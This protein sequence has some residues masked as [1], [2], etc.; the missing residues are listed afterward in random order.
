MC[1][2]IL[3]LFFSDLGIFHHWVSSCHWTRRL[4]LWWF[5]HVFRNLSSLHRYGCWLWRCNLRYPQ[6]KV[7]FLGCPRW[8]LLA[9]EC[10]YFGRRSLVCQSW[11]PRLWQSRGEG[12]R[13][14]GGWSWIWLLYRVFS[15]WG[16]GLWVSRT[17][18]TG[19]FSRRRWY[20]FSWIGLGWMNKWGKM[21]IVRR[22]G[23]WRFERRGNFWH[24]IFW[25]YLRY[26]MS[27]F[28][29]CLA[30]IS[31]LPR[32]DCDLSVRKF[33]PWRRYSR[34]KPHGPVQPKGGT[35]SSGTNRT[36]PKNRLPC[37]GPS[38]P[39]SA[40]EWCYPRDISCLPGRQW[41]GSAGHRWARY[42]RWGWSV[43]P[44]AS[45]FCRRGS[46]Q[47]WYLFPWEKWHH[48]CV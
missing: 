40:D 42:L 25:P 22:W 34:Q 43:L 19:V 23:R 38:A 4:D 26:Q 36:K 48:I 27:L 41:P 29:E 14:I 37:R 6:R 46:I 47:K 21:R 9:H 32:D 35:G 11:R 31:L 1:P 5:V 24:P 45:R 39:S 16:V 10:R 12:L 30:G 7:F 13:C 44:A 15:R 20:V 28:E 17:R 33:Y 3:I 8:L 2:L 18:S